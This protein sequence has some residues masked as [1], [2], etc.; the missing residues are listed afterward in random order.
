VPAGDGKMFGVLVVRDRH[1]KAGYLAA[2]SGLLHGTACHPGFVPPVFDLT[3]GQGFF[4]QGEAEISRL[5]ARIAALEADPDYRALSAWIREETASATHAAREGTARLAAAKRAR[6]AT[7][8]ALL[9]GSGALVEE[10]GV[11]AALV[12]RQH[13]ERLALQYAEKRRAALAA[14][15]L[16]GLHAR[17][18]DQENGIAALRAGR[19]ARSIDLQQRLFREFSFLNARG[20]RRSLLEL[21]REHADGIPPAGAGECAGPR[22]FEH[23]YREGMRPLAMA[24]FWWGEAPPGAVRRHGQFYPACRAKCAPILAHMLGGLDCED[25]PFARAFSGETPLAVIHEDAVL[26]AVE[27][28]P[29]LLAVPGKR[30]GDSLASRLQV[31]SPGMEGP[32][33]VHRLDQATSGILLFAKTRETLVA[34]QRQFAERRVEKRYV[35]LLDGR[36]VGDAGVVEL[37]LRLDPATRPE[38]IVCFE[39][40]KPARTRWEAVAREGARTRVH[41]FPETGRTHQLRLHAAHPLGLGMPIVGD[42]LYGNPG[43][44]L[45]LHAAGLEFMHPLTGRRVRL[46]SGAGF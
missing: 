27:K 34:L 18:A 41:F 3:D 44:R 19:H 4:K 10:S 35:A 37:P 9:A 14:E 42:A 29:G 32:F 28:P 12:A 31:L 25:D 38:R 45:C 36:L 11:L 39:L 24:E 17:L 2:F 16:A 21:F 40:G 1:G 26:L 13:A 33:P 46:E 43:D 23:V 7:R 6:Q 30:T 22:L 15:R 8:D 5:N 20:E